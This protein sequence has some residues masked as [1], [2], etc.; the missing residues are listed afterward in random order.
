MSITRWFPV[1]SR[2]P[3]IP[4]S[5]EVAT[6]RRPSIPDLPQTAAS[7][8]PPSHGSMSPPGRI[9]S[10]MA[11][12]QPHEYTPS[13]LQSHTARQGN[14][15]TSAR[16]QRRG[17]VSSPVSV[18]AV[19][20][21]P[22]NNSSSGSSTTAQS[23]T[24]DPGEDNPDNLE[25]MAQTQDSYYMSMPNGSTQLD[26]ANRSDPPSRT[27]DSDMRG[28]KRPHETV[29][30]NEA[31]TPPRKMGKRLTTKEEVSLFEICNKHADSFGRRSDICNWWRTIATEFTQMH[32]RPYSWHS[33]RRKVETVTKQRVKFLDDQRQR[34]R[35]R[36]GPE[37]GEEMMNPRWCAVVDEWIPTWQRWEAAE[38]RRIKERDDIVHRRAMNR[39]PACDPLFVSARNLGLI[40]R[41]GSSSDGIGAD[42]DQSIG[43]G[44]AWGSH[45]LGASLSPP[46]PASIGAEP[47][48]E[49][50]RSHVHST[51][52]LPPGF[53]TMFSNPQSQSTGSPTPPAPVPA[54]AAASRS[55][56]SRNNRVTGAVLETRGKLNKQLDVAPSIEAPDSLSSPMIR[57][58]SQTTP[59]RPQHQ[60]QDQ[61]PNSSPSASLDIDRIKEELRQEMHAELRRDRA[62]LE[63]RLD[64]VQR[65]QEIILNL[66]RQDFAE[67]D[68]QI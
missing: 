54:A 62:A 63:A 66:L 5:S 53:D 12:V 52:Q 6:P 17:P 32:G 28:T 34:Q 39:I 26:G 3:S 57:A 42:M 18:V 13:P 46:A 48:S 23:A 8:S 9:P 65:T 11:R 2:N 49:P 68:V 15:S 25:D 27:T 16:R 55:N 30:E 1:S 14:I 19:N 7:A 51:V 58:R 41:R 60:N 29:P 61:Q 22:V 37:L 4:A 43:D 44:D 35:D 64:S 31:T 10:S 24:E 47:P 33:V 67:A 50:S 36:S 56:T 59:Q 45:L 21:T 20:Q 38:A 40:R